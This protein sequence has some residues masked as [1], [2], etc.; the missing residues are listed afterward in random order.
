MNRF[1]RVI[2]GFVAQW[3]M[4]DD[5][6]AMKPWMKT[7]I[8]DEPVKHSNKPGTLAFGAAGPNSRTVQCFVNLGH[9]KHL[10]SLGFATFAHV[11]EGME[12]VY[13]IYTGYGEAWP[14]QALLAQQGAA[15]FEKN[16]PLMSYIETARQSPPQSVQQQH[17]QQSSQPQQAP[18]LS[19]EEDISS[20][21]ANLIE[22]VLRLPLL[23]T[24]AAV[25]MLAGGLWFCCRGRRLARV[26]SH[27]DP[28]AV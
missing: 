17:Q 12:H 8:Q 15:Y 28:K 3:G 22:G 2:P 6:H 19:V 18:A 11:T 7:P 25:I 24:L 4:P 13:R 20:Q 23:C 10:D 27:S 26:I 5:P 1:F 16:F 14:N 9:N 21:H